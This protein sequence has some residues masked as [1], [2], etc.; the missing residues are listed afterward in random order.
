MAPKTIFATVICAALLVWNAASAAE[1]TSPT[2]SFASTSPR[3]RY[4]RRRSGR[5][6]DLTPVPAETKADDSEAKAQA[7]RGTEIRTQARCSRTARICG[8]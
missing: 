6:P 4:R 5:R 7:A 3:Q 2:S 1:R 8:Q